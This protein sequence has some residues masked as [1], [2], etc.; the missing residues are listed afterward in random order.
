MIQQ[1]D[2]AT[3]AITAGAV[4]IGG[5]VTG[6]DYATLLAG[7][8]GGLA[9]LSFLPPMTIW[10]R[11]W[12]PVTATLTAGYTAP[13]GIHY[14]EKL[15]GAEGDNA[16]LEIFAAFA[17]GLVAQF[18]IPV[19]IKAAKDRADKKLSSEENAS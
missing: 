8:A 5:V 9:S 6:L 7:L 1:P 15:V 17:T 16:S 4:T 2:V 18:I 12:T 19:A 13:L 3:A 10:R 14:L 11:I